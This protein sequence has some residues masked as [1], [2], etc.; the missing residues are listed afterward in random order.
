V[1]LP[2]GGGAVRGVGESFR[3]NPA[4]G[5]GTLTIPLP[6]SPGRAGFGPELHL[7]YDTGFG[8]GPFGMGF[9]LA[10]PAVS[11]RTDRRCPTYDDEA[12]ADTF[13]LSGSEDLVPVL[14]ASGAVV[15]YQRTVGGSSFTVTRYR[16][17]IEGSH[18][19]IERWS[20]NDTGETHWRT[21]SNS[22]VTTVYG[23]TR[24]ERIADPA[25]PRRVLTWLATESSDALGNAI[26]YEYAAE[27]SVGVDVRAAHE[28]NRSDVSRSANRYLT[29]V[30]YG[31]TTSRL[32]IDDVADTEWL[33]ELAFDYGDYDPADPRPSTR[34]DW[35][36]R[37]DPFS[38]YRA[39]F[40]VRTYRLCRRILMFHHFPDEPDV[41]AECLVRSLDLV[42][43]GSELASSDP[44]GPRTGQLLRTATLTGH[45]QTGSGPASLS[46][47]S[48]ELDYSPFQPAG[49]LRVVRNESPHEPAA[50]ASAEQRVQHTWVDLDGVGVPGLLNYDEQAMGYAANLGEGQVAPTVPLPIQP[51]VSLADPG[52]TLVDLAGDGSLDLVTTSREAPGFFERTSD[53]GWATYRSFIRW[54]D[55]DW[56]DPDLRFVDLDGDGLAEV[57]TTREHALTWYP[58]LGEDGYDA[59]RTTPIAVDDEAGPRVLF[60]APGETVHL[61]DLSGDGLLDLVRIT[62]DGV[63]YWPSL[64]HGRFG[65][66]VTMDTPPRLSRDEQFDPRRLILA[67]VDGSGPSDLVYLG[68]G[69]ACFFLNQLGN[70]WS[71]AIDLPELP[72]LDD[73]TEVSVV[74]LLGRGTACLV[75]SSLPDDRTIRF[76]ELCP[77]K[78]RLLSQ[79]RNNMGA[80]TTI[81]YGTS[82]RCYLDDLAQGRSWLWQV[83]F[84]VQVVTRVTTRNAMSSVMV[85]E[86]VF[87][88]GCWDPHDREFR[89]FAM[90]EEL[91]TERVESVARPQPA[92]VGVLASSPP[93][94]KRSWFHTGVPP[95]SSARRLD[96][97]YYPQVRRAGLDPTAWTLAESSIPSGLSPEAER[98]AVRALRGQT[99]REEV[100]A[101]DSTVLELHPYSVVDRRY[102][103][104]MLQ[105]PT[106]GRAG[107]FTTYRRETLN[108]S[109]ERDPDDPR[110]THEV[111]LDVDDFGAVTHA[112]EVAYGR[113]TVDPGLPASAQAVQ[114]TT[115][116]TET[117]SQVTDAVDV[118][119]PGARDDYRTPVVWLTT[120]NQLSGPAVD[121]RQARLTFAEVVALVQVT[122]N[123]V[124]RELLHSQRTQHLADDLSGPLALGHQGARGLTL[125][126][127][128]LAF[129]GPLLDEALGARV[130]PG[131]MVAAGYVADGD[132]WWAP[133]GRIMPAPA[134]AADPE[135]FAIDHFFRLVRFTDPFGAET[136][137]EYDPYHLMAVQTVDP[138][139]N[140]TTAGR[141][142][143]AGAI[144]QLALDFR[145][146]AP[147]LV[148][149]VNGNAT[150]TVY[151]ALGL[152]AATA[153]MGKA[154]DDTGDRVDPAA[155]VT[156]AADVAAFWADPQARAAAL[157][158]GATTRVVH[159]LGAYRRTL[160]SASVQPCGIATITRDTHVNGVGPAV[161]SCAFG[162]FDGSGESLQHKLPAE[163]ATAT[164]A[165]TP[166]SRWVGSGWTVRDNKGRV[167]RKYEPFFTAT[168]EFEFAVVQGVSPVEVFDPLGR[169][170][171]TLHPDR[172]W[173][174]V[175]RSAWQVETWDRND[176]IAIDDPADDADVGEWLAALDPGLVRPTWAEAR[177][178][179]ALGTAALEAV[180]KT[181]AHAGTTTVM[182]LDPRGRP[183]FTTVWNSVPRDGQPP[184]RAARRH[185][186]HL[187]IHGDQRAITEWTDDSPGP[188]SAG[189]ERL[190]MRS[191][192]DLVRN[193]VVLESL[194]AGTRRQLVDVLGREVLAW[195]DLGADPERQLRTDYDLLRRPVGVTVTEPPSGARTLTRTTYGEGAPNSAAAN[196]RGRPWRFSDQAGTQTLTYDRAGNV[197]RN[198]RRFTA[199]P[200][201]PVDWSG[202]VTLASGNLTSTAEYDALDRLVGEQH[203]DGSRVSYR[204][205]QAGLMET[206][207]VRLPG[208]P[209]DT[210]IVK[211]VDYDAKGQRTSIRFGNGVVSTYAYEP[212]T[213]RLRS[214]RTRRQPEPA[215]DRGIPPDT[216]VGVQDLTYVYDPSGNVMQVRDLAQ[217]RVFG[218]NTVVDAS[219][220]YTYDA[221][222]Q[223]VAAEGREHLGRTGGTLRPP[224]PTSDTDLPRIS[225][226][227]PQALGRYRETYEYDAS[228]NLRRLRHR[229]TAPARN[230][231]T[232]SF[233]YEEASPLVPTHLT[234]RV[235]RARV[236]ATTDTYG[237]D[238]EGNMVGLRP[239]LQ[240]LVWDHGG[241]LASS[242]RQAVTT[243][244]PETTY[245]DYDIEGERV[246]KTTR[247]AAVT[248]AAATVRAERV[249]VGNFEVYRELGSNGKETLRRT[250]LHVSDGAV[251]IA[252][253]DRRTDTGAVD[254]VVRYQLGNMLGST[255]VELDAT[256]T[257]VSYE[258]FYPFGSTALLITNGGRPPKRYRMSAKERDEESGLYYFGARY[259]APWLCR[260]LSPDPAGV[261][262]GLNVYV[263]ARDNPVTRTDP[264]GRESDFERNAAI[265]RRAIDSKPKY[266][267]IRNAAA[268]NRLAAQKGDRA[269]AAREWDR[270]KQELTKHANEGMKVAFVVWA[271]MALAVASG[272]TGGLAGEAVIAAS[273]TPAAPTLGV[274]LLAGAFGGFVGGS[275]DVAGE[276]GLRAFLGERI[277]NEGEVGAR[278]AFSAA[279]P[280][281]AT[282]AL[283]GLS[284]LTSLIRSAL[285]AQ[286]TGGVLE[287]R[288][289]VPKFKSVGSMGTP[290]TELEAVHFVKPSGFP[291]P[292]EFAA[293][294]A[295][296]KNAIQDLIDEE[297][298]AGLQ[299]RILE[300]RANKEALVALRSEINGSLGSAGEGMVWSHHPDM[301][302]GADPFAIGRSADARVNSIIGAASK[303][304]AD[305]ILAINASEN[306]WIRVALKAVIVW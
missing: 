3:T 278:I 228:G 209:A 196:L 81:E 187:D 287:L 113:R 294:L 215:T 271:F 240:S 243:G 65:M 262:D 70:S 41:G 123:T 68:E 128:Q 302:I 40:E 138:L 274:K 133:S 195:E 145:A 26:S 297:G 242:S 269:A 239:T 190:V 176:T 80:E 116:M 20:R 35:L 218:F 281:L 213:M 305:Q 38:S 96:D 197:T 289:V 180:Q 263:Y 223:L 73:E 42:H 44:A 8:N 290:V 108:I 60:A 251:R 21:I 143:T 144:A 205:N 272:V 292:D 202:T 167:V 260:W 63:S 105:P 39:G 56:D 208:D 253:I 93:V 275:V 296:H 51:S 90:V 106:H 87:H 285:P 149:D 157:L 177:L 131:D 15:R 291:N 17:R 268:A 159:D 75:L 249:Y 52:T 247:R 222:Y 142:N 49:D 198:V 19:R 288:T 146:L 250:T 248:A 33:F 94:M 191:K 111:V 104:D 23:R 225:P 53:G 151:D 210:P 255:V 182:S 276:Q 91:D 181:Q 172:S 148:T 114:A 132:S 99:L 95:Q 29:A 64:G 97:E 207:S 229:G 246:R 237:Y 270:V 267:A 200:G 125:S 103:V 69:Q 252:T 306:P 141:V 118:E 154:G 189:D 84:P 220:E 79:V 256:S 16:S 18:A 55:L 153:V 227:D 192:L 194:D 34:G 4:T 124:R 77:T 120:T 234:N 67:D 88:H 137:V 254:Q 58:S 261:A 89:G 115:T 279:I 214:I 179:G 25:D 244:V 107:V 226:N 43:S 24:S 119:D 92:A 122:D 156:S 57:L 277:L 102:A 221:L 219:C 241:R 301:V 280:V 76:L 109:S 85:R 59:A 98:E 121:E 130:G 101:L 46:M 28:R 303:Q 236:G 11:R 286:A 31:N 204:F 170:V 45:L 201:R 224:R 165:G 160:G 161:V 295:A 30:R 2:K 74:D 14:S 32:R 22:N 273:A 173:E 235:S 184:R 217:P 139:G 82:T 86:Y 1:E 171:V 164:G 62:A 140:R 231:W 230:G 299:A 163:P 238:P 178:S 71:R 150:A 186:V 168:H 232:R 129:T 203:P 127:E 259:Y 265:L 54:P 136:R 48:I 147:T 110:V 258:E 245:Y 50:P 6:I 193:R 10:I 5:S 72:R 211:G 13:L 9:S 283:T 185:L 206:V 36:A 304:W 175:V 78:P 61:A 134:G 166:T 300:Y 212:D 298:V 233:A 12:D 174:K 264:D 83:P 37:D 135:G 112:V 152:V 158:G 117:R 257:L 293:E 162:Y 169:S 66:K 216:R 188:A 100:Y 7:A 126:Q 155:S 266:E 282:G 284:K 183:V 47:P 27:N 199:D